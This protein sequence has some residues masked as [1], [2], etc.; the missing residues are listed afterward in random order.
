MNPGLRIGLCVTCQHIKIIKS[1][2]G[3]TFIMCN[4]AKTDPRFRKYPPLPVIACPGYEA[5]PPTG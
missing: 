1:S 4:L 2:R 3:S 5:Q